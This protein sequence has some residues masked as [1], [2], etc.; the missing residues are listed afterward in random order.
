[1]LYHEARH[2]EKGDRCRDKLCQKVVEILPE[3]VDLVLD[4]ALRDGIRVVT[5]VRVKNFIRLIV[6]SIVDRFILVGRQIW[7]ASFLIWNK[8][9]N[10]RQILEPPV[11]V[12]KDVVLACLT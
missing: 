7:V 4:V 5:K 3:V 8:H 2:S 12:I 10:D 6:V 1:M 11:V 9:F